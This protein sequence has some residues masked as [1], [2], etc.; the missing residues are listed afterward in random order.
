ML[1]FGCFKKIST[2]PPNNKVGP[3]VVHDNCMI[4][5]SSII[6]PD[7]EIGPNSVVG[8]RSI[9][10]RDVPPNTVC[11]GNPAAYIE[12]YDEYLEKS[13]LTEIDIESAA[14]VKE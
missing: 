1:A 7:V 13:R 6:M 2:Q 11:A 4:G 10:T 12:S 9:V 5:I 3:I 8:A 14:T